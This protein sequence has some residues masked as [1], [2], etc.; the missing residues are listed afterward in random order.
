MHP[1]LRHFVRQYLGVVCLP[2][3]LV[4]TVAFVSMPF[5]LGGHPGEPRATAANIERH[6]T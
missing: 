5:T 2:L 6:M 1:V 4:A 3:L